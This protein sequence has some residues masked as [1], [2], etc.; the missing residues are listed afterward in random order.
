MATIETI[1]RLSDAQN[2]GQWIEK[3][4]EVIDAYNNSLGIIG[5]SSAAI[6]SALNSGQIGE[7]LT[8]PAKTSYNDYIKNGVYYVPMTV[9]NRPE[10]KDVDTNL[11]VATNGT[12]ITQLA[13]TI[14]TEAKLYIRKGS[15]DGT[16][17]T[18]EGWYNIPSRDYN[19]STYLMLSGSDTQIEGGI[20][21][22]STTF[23]NVNTSTLNVNDT[24]TFYGLVNIDHHGTKLYVSNNGQTTIFDAK[25]NEPQVVY[26]IKEDGSI[27]NRNNIISYYLFENKFITYINE[28][29][30]QRNK[31]TFT[32]D[33]NGTDK[34]PYYIQEDNTI[35]LQKDGRDP[36]G[37]IKGNVIYKD[38]GVKY[39]L[40][41]DIAY[42]YNIQLYVKNDAIYT[43]SAYTS[44]R[45]YIKPHPT[46]IK[47]QNIIEKETKYYLHRHPSYPAADPVIATTDKE[48]NDIQFYIRN[49]VFYTEDT[50]E[51]PVLYQHENVISTDIDGINVLYT[52]ED[53]ENNTLLV[54]DEHILYYI[55]N[56]IVY[57]Q[58]KEGE[59]ELNPSIAMYVMEDTLI[60]L[61]E[62][63]LYRQYL[64]DTITEDDGGIKTVYYIQNNTNTITSDFAGNNV[65]LYYDA[66]QGIIS[67]KNE[68]GNLVVLY[69]VLDD[70]IRSQN[71][72]YYIQEDN[73]ITSDKEGLLIHY[74][75]SGNNV[76]QNT[77]PITVNM[78][79]NVA[80]IN[81]TSEYAQFLKNTAF[82]HSYLSGTA[83]LAASGKA[84][85]DLY[86]YAKRKYMPY[87][88]GVFTGLVVHQDDLRIGTNNKNEPC[89][90]YSYND[91][92]ILFSS[93]MS[94]IANNDWCEFYLDKQNEPLVPNLPCILGAR[95]RTGVTP[96]TVGEPVY[97]LGSI[98]FT[99]DCTTIRLRKTNLTRLDDD[100]EEKTD[101]SLLLERNDTGTSFRPSIDRVVSLGTG[102]MRYSHVYSASGDISTSDRNLKTDIQEIDERLLDRWKYINWKSFKFKDSVD[103]KGDNARTH[104]GLIA[105]EVE[106]MLGDVNASKYGFFCIDSW[107]DI[108]D[109]QYITIPAT[110]DNSGVMIEPEQKRKVVS[111]KKAAG[112]QLSLRYQEIQAIE[113]AYL[114][115]EIAFLK[116]ELEEI[117][118]LI[119]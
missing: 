85:F 87:E 84:V 49:G 27:V 1:E 81:G 82:T 98:E 48:G 66:E 113:N 19:D 28:Y 104:T 76:I 50:Y 94:V 22:G 116:K 18:F 96:N 56:D 83:T 10:N 43:D 52:V 97:A 31:D 53:G 91:L 29:Y 11:Y 6:T 110:Y 17:T 55:E 103:E 75:L 36:R 102:A 42:T 119:K 24:A 80:H 67:E 106:T 73:T 16:T 114:R 51:N 100:D 4:N 32:I 21:V 45:Y 44:L 92:D 69:Y 78:S 70:I 107:D 60:I 59:E 118:N 86:N 89:K 93:K 5:S 25:S 117:K 34:N 101:V 41:N 23:S 79:D 115:R 47:K 30:I 9:K 37:H 77:S 68:D 61:N 72:V 39:F 109:T 35:S 64:L 38:N 20:T 63:V 26:T 57:S 95:T 105:Q 108:Y 112:H 8:T 99:E 40:Y 15:Y 3:I 14:E 2:F 58:P 7:T 65:E 54:I 46:D 13:V 62:K 88:G 111:L 12:S 71:I 74:K 90:I 33:E